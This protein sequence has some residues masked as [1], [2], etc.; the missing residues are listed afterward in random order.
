MFQRKLVALTLGFVLCCTALATYS[1]SASSDFSFGN[2]SSYIDEGGAYHLYGEIR[3]DSPRP[4]SSIVIGAVFED[5]NGRVLG[6]SSASPALHTLNPGASSSFEIVFLDSAQSRGVAH[7]VLSAV[8]KPSQAKTDAL[9]IVSSNSRLDLLGTYYINAIIRNNSPQNATNTEMVATL[10]DKSGAVVAIGRALAE[11]EPGNADIPAGGQAA[12]GIAVTDKLQT[13]K[14]AW[15]TLISESDQFFSN[16]VLLAPKNSTYGAPPPGSNPKSGCL[17]ATA[18]YGDALAPQVQELRTFRDGIIIPTASGS[19]FMG[20][21]NAWYY[22]FSPNV[23]EVE[24]HNP[25]LQSLVRI[26]IFPLLSILRASTGI[27]ALLQSSPELAVV[28]T[29]I[30]ASAVIGFVYLGAPISLAALFTRNRSIELG[31]AAELNAVLFLGALC[32]VVTAYTLDLPIVESMATSL[33]V[34]STMGATCA[35]VFW[36][37][38]S[39][40]LSRLQTRPSRTPP[41]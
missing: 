6:N 36:I 11:A 39:R 31:R 23:A 8:G 32:I 40:I 28:G 14:T 27:H 4:A 29:G 19:A 1:A 35:L 26:D 3:N 22:S 38:R 2:E 9:V 5:G 25:A 18:A 10:F 30:F 12:F 16:E 7:Y 33:L 41:P 20:A 21:F 15:Y 13:Y 37:V 24:R 17:I 34:L